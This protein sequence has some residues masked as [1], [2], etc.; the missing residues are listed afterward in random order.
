MIVYVGRQHKGIV[1]GSAL[2][3]VTCEH[4]ATAYH[5]EY[6]CI[7]EGKATSHYGIN[8][9]WARERALRSASHSVARGLRS[10]VA[11]VA[12]PKCGGIQ[13][14]MVADLRRRYRRRWRMLG[15]VIPGVLAVLWVGIFLFESNFFDDPLPEQAKIVL[16]VMGALA[17]ACYLLF[18]V[19]IWRRS[20]VLGNNHYGRVPVPVGNR[21]A[22]PVATVVA[23]DPLNA[24]T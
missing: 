17:V 22:A 13:A 24:R 19:W 11:P 1:Q 20:L 14:D 4:C 2:K 23:A 7:A 12:C 16:A 3:D 8:E 9:A 5:H 15:E 21:G 10:G 6:R 18:G